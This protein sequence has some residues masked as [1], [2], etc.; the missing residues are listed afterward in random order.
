MSKGIRLSEQHGVNPS[1][2][3]CF[4]CGEVK[5][6]MFLGKLKGDA[7]APDKLLVDY[8]P[9]ESCA[10]KFK[11]GILC[12]E[13]STAP[14]APNQAPIAN[15]AYPTGRWTV[16]TEAVIDKL[17]SLSGGRGKSYFDAVREKRKAVVDIPLYKIITGGK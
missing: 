16:T 2:Q 1:K 10:E 8:E 6:L 13:T 14:I 9:C 4:F 5:G 3:V 11:Q 15:G 7:K 17:I 12:I